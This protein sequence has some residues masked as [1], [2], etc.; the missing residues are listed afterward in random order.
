[1]HAR[2]RLH[3]CMARQ[4][5]LRERAFLSCLSCFALY[6]LAAYYNHSW[7]FATTWS[8]SAVR[9]V[10]K[11]EGHSTFRVLVVLPAVCCDLVP[12]LENSCLRHVSQVC[13]NFATR[14]CIVKKGTSQA[15]ACDQAL[16]H[17]RG[18]ND[19]KHA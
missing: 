1:M 14:S 7:R 11:W 16:L 6:L 12:A 17:Q 9:R 19:V 8:Y 5:R 18:S 2:R 3:D 10:Q 13:P 15:D 4:R